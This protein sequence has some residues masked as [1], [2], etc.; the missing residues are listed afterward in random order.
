MQTLQYTSVTERTLEELQRPADLLKALSNPL[1]LAIVLE[2][3]ADDR[4]VHEIVEA[5]GATQALVSQHLRVLR[6]ANVVTGQ[7]RGKEIAYRLADDH[8]THI[9]LDA[10]IHTDE[11][12][13]P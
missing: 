2:L 6:G 10:I 11:G 3:R 7:R 4:C 12:A 8:I 1:R 9:V 13:N 5:V